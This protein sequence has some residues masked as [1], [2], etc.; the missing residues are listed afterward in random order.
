MRTR[1]FAVTVLSF[2]LATTSAGATVLIKGDNGGLME[3][4]VARFQPGDD[5]V[6]TTGLAQRNDR[7]LVQHRSLA[8]HP[9]ADTLRVRHDGAAR[10][11]QRD[12]AEFHAANGCF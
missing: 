9:L 6:L 12:R 10:F 3:D 11:L 1:R 2:A 8:D 7:A 5:N 4:Y